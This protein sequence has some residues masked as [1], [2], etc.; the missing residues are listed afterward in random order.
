MAASARMLAPI[1]ALFF[2][3]KPIDRQCPRLAHAA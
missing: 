3:A 2:A 1:L